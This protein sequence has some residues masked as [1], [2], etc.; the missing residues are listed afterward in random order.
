MLC[1]YCRCQYGA[2]TDFVTRVA[3]KTFWLYLLLSHFPNVKLNFY[4]ARG[5]IAQT[6]N[7]H[8]KISAPRPDW[9]YSVWPG[10]LAEVSSSGFFFRGNRMHCMYV[11][12]PR[13]LSRSTAALPTGKIA[14][15]IGMAHFPNAFKILMAACLFFFQVTNTNENQ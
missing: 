15:V 1:Y 12:L 9:A 8:Y 6:I 2:Y 7:S 5:T 3:V 11:S 4:L 14:L 13:Q 10:G